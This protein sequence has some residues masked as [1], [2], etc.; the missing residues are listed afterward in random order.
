MATYP[1]QVSAQGDVPPVRTRRPGLRPVRLAR[2]AGVPVLLSPS[3]L[4]VA[5]L[6]TLLFAPTAASATGLGQGVPAY[7]VA[8]VL[9][10]LLAVS[11]LAHEAAHAVA[12]RAFGLRVDRVVVDLWGGHTSL[13]R[14]QSPGASAVVSVVGPLVNVLLAVVAE[15]ARRQL[16]ATLEPGSTVAVV[17]FLLLGTAV[18]NGLVGVFN[19]VPGLPL[20]GGRVLEALVWR[21]TGNQDTG[22]LVAGWAGRVVAVAAVLWFVGPALLQGRL[23]STVSLVWVVL[24]A[25][26]LWRGASASIAVARFRRR[27]AGVDLRSVTRSAAVAHAGSSVSDVVGLLQ[28]LPPGSAATTDVVLVDDH[29]RPVAV[30]AGGSV[31]DVPDHLRTTTPA[32]AVARSLTAGSVVAASSGS[33]GAVEGLARSGDLGIVLVDELG[34]PAGRVHPDEFAAAMGLT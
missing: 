23:P 22:S 13:G 32:S 17:A 33:L 10:V 16:P 3:W 14:P 24:I 34:R 15:G 5:A 26:F 27:A 2:V 20:D 30:V 11:V 29:G 1:R 28:G 19:L 31:A 9:A 21:V 7:L 8:L 12:A 4:L 18:M 6:V 25:W